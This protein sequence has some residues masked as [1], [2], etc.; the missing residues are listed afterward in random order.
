MDHHKKICTL[1]YW[2]NR[3]ATKSNWISRPTLQSTSNRKRASFKCQFCDKTFGRQDI[4]DAHVL[5]D[6]TEEKTLQESQAGNPTINAKGKTVDNFDIHPG[7]SGGQHV[8]EICGK[9][10]TIGS[11]LR[12]HW[13]THTG[14]RLFECEV[15]GKCFRTSSN[16][17][18]HSYIHK[19]A[20]FPCHLCNKL[21]KTR[22][23]VKNHVYSTHEKRRPPRNI[24]KE[25]EDEDVEII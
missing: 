19:D 8:C 3:P 21:F 11:C 13:S 1:L 25:P 16:L 20:T 4:L 23:N 9:C 15:C 18:E 7:N 5:I 17:K 2:I 12:D 10:F 14:E 22:K 6:H 24:K